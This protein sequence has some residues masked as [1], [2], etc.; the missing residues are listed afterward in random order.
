[1]TILFILITA[2]L[3][4]VSIIALETGFVAPVIAA[5]DALEEPTTG[6][7]GAFVDGIRWAFNAIGA[8]FKLAFFQVEG[9]PPAYNSIFVLFT[10]IDVFILVRVVRG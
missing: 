10:L 4:L 6:V 1:M 7:I 5:P 3:M 8:F 2:G 9:L